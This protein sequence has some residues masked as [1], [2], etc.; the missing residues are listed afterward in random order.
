MA[1]KIIQVGNTQI[2]DISDVFM[3]AEIG[4]NHNGDLQIAKK[5][6][7]AA[8]ACNFH[9][10]KFQKRTPELA[11][12]ESQKNIIRDTPWGKISYLE[13]KHKI[14]FEKNEYDYIDHYCREKPVLWSVSVWDLPSLEFLCNYDVP[15]IKIPSAML[16]NSKLLIEVCLTEKPIFL[17]TGMS[18]IEEIDQAVDLLEKHTDGNYVVMHTN[19]SYPAP[20]E[21]LNLRVISM[22][23]ERYGCIVGYSGH[24]YNLEP[25]VAAVVLGARVV[26][27]HITLD[28]TMWGTDQSASLEVHAMDM[29][30]KRIKDIGKMLGDG[31]KKITE[32]ELV[33]RKKLRGC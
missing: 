6:I 20:S 27:R 10:V 22:L 14:E 16:T 31:E 33:V 25:T 5:L 32:T 11:V 30:Y 12:P 23:K 29:L 7:D 9:C 21:E 8:F 1:S 19:S 28:H 15:F 13:Y 4:I 26:E 18:A 24:E 17:S 3:V 2:S